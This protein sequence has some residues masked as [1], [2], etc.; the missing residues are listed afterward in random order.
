M[1][2]GIA[3]RRLRVTHAGD[4]RREATVDRR[5]CEDRAQRLAIDVPPAL[6]S[7]RPRTVIVN[8]VPASARRSTSAT[9]LRNSRCGIVRLSMGLLHS[10]AV[11]HRRPRTVLDTD[12]DRFARRRSR[13]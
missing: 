10:V 3:D 7:G 5:V 1:L 4:V 13:R 11:T 9:L 12:P 2:P 6:A 8:S